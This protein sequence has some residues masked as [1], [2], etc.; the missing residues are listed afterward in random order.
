MKKII[1]ALLAIIICLSF[2]GCGKT[3]CSIEG[4]EN[5]A[6]EDTTYEEV[7]CNKH[8]SSKKAFEVSKAAYD[9]IGVAYEII[10]QISSD[11]Y[12]VWLLGIYKKDELIENGSEYLASD[13]SLSEDE[14]KSGIGCIIAELFGSSWENASEEDKKMYSNDADIWLSFYKDDLATFCVFSVINAYEINGKMEEA[15]IALDAAKANMK[16]LSEKYS[17]YEHYPNLKGYYTTT[18]S[19]FDFCQ[20]PTGSFEQAK[21]TINDY[22]NEAR[23]YASDLDYI[24]ED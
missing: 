22:K 20:N 15:Q 23:D 19:F 1:I 3:M 13:L 9:N 10:E 11:I 12:H 7:L 4:C 24:F 6:V 2:C 16:E 18:S 21:E 5:E 17:D 8:L 14:I